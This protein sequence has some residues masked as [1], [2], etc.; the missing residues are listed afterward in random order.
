VVFYVGIRRYSI[1]YKN[2]KTGVSTSQVTAIT[3][4]VPEGNLRPLRFTNTP[5]SKGSTI[6]GTKKSW[7]RDFGTNQDILKYPRQ[8][9]DVNGDG[10]PD[11]VAF[12]DD[13]VVVSLNKG[14]NSF[15]P[16]KTWVRGGFGFGNG[17]REGKDIRLVEDVNG[18]GLGDI[19]GFG[20]TGVYVALSTGKKFSKIQ[21]WSKD[22]SSRAWRNNTFIRTLSDMNGDGLPDLV[23]FGWTGVYVALNTGHGFAGAKKWTSSFASKDW[24]N[25]G[26]I[27]TLSDVNGDGLPDIIGFGWKSVVVALNNGH[28]F[29][30]AKRWTND[31]TTEKWQNRNFIRTLSDVNGD[32]LPDIVGF[33]HSGVQ[34]GIN[35]GKGFKK[36]RQWI[37]DFGTQKGYD[38]SKHIRTLAD[39]DGDGLNDIVAFAN[40]AVYVGLNNGHGFN[41]ALRAANASFTYSQCW[42]VGINQRGLPDMNLDGLPDI[43][44]FGGDAVYVGLNQRKH[45]L[46]TRINNNTNQ[47]IQIEYK[48]MK[49]KAVYYN[50]TTHGKRN[51]YG[52][53]KITN[54]NIELTT[55][56]P[57]VY[58][59]KQINGVK[60]YSSM[61]YFYT[62]YIYNKIRGIQGFHAINTYDETRKTMS[63]VYYK[64]IVAKNGAGF[65]YTGMPSVSL[66]GGDIKYNA[67]L[68]GSRWHSRTDIMYKDAKTRRMPSRNPKE[69]IV[70]A[71]YEP[72]TYSNV[73]K[74]YDPDSRMHKSSI[75]R[76]NTISQDGLGNI[77]K[78][79]E[80]T[81]DEFTQK[82][83]DKVTINEYKAED[84]HRWI[85][86]RLTKSTTTHTQ[87]D[88]GT[89]RRAAT[90]KYNG[91]GL[92][93]EE[94]TNA[95][96]ALALKKNYLYDKF[97]NKIQETISGKDMIT[98]TTRFGYSKDHKFQTSITNAAG[99]KTT[100]TFDAAFGTVKSVSNPNGTSTFKYDG[101]GRKIEEHRA[102]GSTTRWLYRWYGKGVLNTRNL[103]FVTE[104]TSGMPNKYLFYDALERVTSSYTTELGGKRLQTMLKYY[105]SIGEL[106]KEALPYIHGKDSI[107]FIDYTYDKYGRLIKTQKPGPNGKTQ[108]SSL[109]YMGGPFGQGIQETLPS[110]VTKFKST[111][112]IG[113][114]VALSDIGKG[115]SISYKY[116]AAGQL[117]QTK[118]AKNNIITMKYDSAGNKIYMNDPDLGIWQYRYNPMGQLRYQWSGAGTTNESH[119]FTVNVYDILG[120]LR[121][122]N[123][124]DRKV[125]LSSSKKDYTYN[126]KTFEYSKSTGRLTKSYVSS[127]SHGKDWHGEYMIPTYDKIGRVIQSDK[128]IYG[129]GHY[130]SKISYDN[131]SRVNKLTYPNGYSV[132]NHYKNGILD[133]VKGSDGKVHYKINKLSALGQV[134]QAQYANGVKTVTGYN[135]AGFAK[136]IIS[137]TSTA[138]VGNI[139]RLDYNYDIMGNVIKREDTSISGKHISD[140]YGYDKADRLISQRTD[141]NVLGNYRKSVSYEYDSIG[142]M[143]YQTGIGF[144][145]YYSKIGKPHAVKSIGTEPFGI[146]PTRKYTYDAVGNVI[147]RNGDKISYTPHNKV[148]TITG[149]NGKTVNYYYGIGDKRYIKKT[150]KSTIYYVGKG[151]EEEVEGSQ[152]KQTCYISIG[153][154]TIGTHVEKIDETYSINKKNPKYKQTYNRYFHMDALGS[155]TAVTD[156]KAKVVERR[157]YDAFGK[158]RAM[159]YG[160]TNNHAIIPQN[161][162]VETTRA[163]TGH[164]QIKEIEGLIHMNARIYDSEI[165]RFL[166]ADTVIQDP[167]DSQAYNRYSYVRNNPLKY[168][169]PT[170]HIFGIGRWV[171]K[172]LRWVDRHILQPIK[173]SKVG[174]AIGGIVSIAIG[175][176]LTYIGN[177]FGPPLMSM[178]VDLLNH[179]PVKFHVQVNVPIGG[180]S[181]TANEQA[182]V[183]HL[184]Q[185]S[186]AIDRAHAG[187][188]P[189]SASPVTND[190]YA[191]G[192]GDMVYDAN[193]NRTYQNESESVRRS[194]QD[195]LNRRVNYLRNNGSALDVDVQNAINHEHRYVGTP[196]IFGGTGTYNAGKRSSG[197][198]DYSFM[199]FVQSTEIPGLGVLTREERIDYLILHESNH[200]GPRVTTYNP[201]TYTGTLGPRPLMIDGELKGHETNYALKIN[202]DFIRVHPIYAF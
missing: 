82:I 123:N 84:I 190:N 162:V 15:A 77:V 151:Y 149:K 93:S 36:S 184:E 181:S 102:D 19:I 31:F 73:E 91:Y 86:G 122:S 172:G 130:I 150:Q 45:S 14:N 139:Q 74:I 12:A 62:G 158:I 105:N 71:V 52:F 2:N 174:R 87:T 67:H 70:R 27:R 178:G 137:Y 44:G 183:E 20:E 133:F 28:G 135:D 177:P 144:Y 78:V 33:G 88:G 63:S 96:T 192:S 50:Y 196:Y 80:R 54:D 164:E 26:F 194:R 7:I 56:M 4:H 202:Q 197:R 106:D 126:Y 127:K 9:S 46:L 195:L 179:N 101:L 29:S 57:L 167:L 159:D 160:L 53:N 5:I 60:G 142:N 43:V 108:T 72:Y 51:A 143:T 16:R 3:E 125:Y 146:N 11:I 201:Y 40:S 10:F 112:A 120:R 64:Q 161:S 121:I 34:V 117:I 75:Y 136:S 65:Q 169:D 76:Y 188:Q 128:F 185:Q 119:H 100:Q 138:L 186:T 85:I 41:K 6:F 17:W 166:S 168:T 55:S 165:G 1:F 199:P 153:G 107:K 148:A 81:K 141:S 115:T 49:D 191:S 134:E 92:L 114:T 21:R 30:G 66:E 38:I 94:V 182:Q 58:R 48:P 110:G 163:Y 98:A 152:K 42:R 23:G 157:S 175:A 176:V 116:D 32:G 200:Y 68:I 90:F 131:L 145:N 193:G 156:D 89:V 47:D 198:V 18:D 59:V 35:T 61:R 155:I 113:Q 97:G 69:G 83:F 8:I 95:G 24:Q 37:S 39:V 154:K 173:N 22:F 171:K 189:T 187:V 124:Y 132:T 140:S 109:R 170:G 147:D 118:D 13:G 79:V 25:R 129:S 104:V 103:Y 180:D 99:I 111:N